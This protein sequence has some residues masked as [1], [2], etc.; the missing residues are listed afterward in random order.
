MKAGNNRLRLDVRVCVEC[1]YGTEGTSPCNGLY[2]CLLHVPV[3]YS[4]Y[5]KGPAYVRNEPH[6]CVSR[7]KYV[8][9]GCVRTHDHKPRQFELITKEVLNGKG[10]NRSGQ[11]SM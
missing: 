6:L 9:T 8:P 1:L 5:R 11:E 7:C 3:R 10:E 4:Q 2:Y